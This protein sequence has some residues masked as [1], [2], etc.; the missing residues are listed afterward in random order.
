M[1]TTSF[2]ISNR[3]AVQQALYPQKVGALAGC[4]VVFGCQ[5]QNR[6]ICTVGWMVAR[7][8]DD[9][10]SR[11][12]CTG[13]SLPYPGTWGGSPAG[14][15]PGRARSLP[16]SRRGVRHSRLDTAVQL[17]DLHPAAGTRGA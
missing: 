1:L 2:M 9:R 11:T 15:A 12:G 4:S 6:S 7:G 10:S 13:Q 8:R 14:I 5:V 3:R 17:G 16:G